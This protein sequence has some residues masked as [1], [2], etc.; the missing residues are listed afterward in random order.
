MSEGWREMLSVMTGHRVK[1]YEFRELDGGRVLVL[2]HLCGIGKTSGLD[3]G[4]LR[5]SIATL[6][7]VD[8]GK[9][10]R[11]VNYID[12]ACALDDLGL[13]E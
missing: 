4:Q 13:K 3:L 11:L 10:T 9:V 6:F 1:A 5:T 12:S 8:D 2:F 7:H